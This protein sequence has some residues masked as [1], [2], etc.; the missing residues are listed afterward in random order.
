MSSACYPYVIRILAHPYVI[1]KASVHIAIVKYS[2]GLLSDLNTDIGNEMSV[3][4]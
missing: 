4:M 2:D 3:T 1:R